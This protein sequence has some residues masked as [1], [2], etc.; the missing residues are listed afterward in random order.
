MPDTFDSIVADAKRRVVA[1]AGEDA[2]PIDDARILLRA[3]E[4][5]E[6][7][8]AGLFP[9]ATGALLD[10]GIEHYIGARVGP[11]LARTLALVPIPLPEVS[12]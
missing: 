3:L 2:L 5:L 7:D 8:G 10:R 11:A 6:A 4:D 1:L 9:A 12:T